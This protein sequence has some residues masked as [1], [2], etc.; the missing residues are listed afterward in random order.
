MEINKKD[1]HLYSEMGLKWAHRR[2]YDIMGITSNSST[3]CAMFLCCRRRFFT[4]QALIS[5]VAGAVF[6]ALHTYCFALRA[7]NCCGRRYNAPWVPI[8]G[9]RKGGREVAGKGRKGAE[10]RGLGGG[11]F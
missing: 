2:I 3:A 9:A 8:M 5:C 4:P 1:G 11:P 7:P 10:V 6:S